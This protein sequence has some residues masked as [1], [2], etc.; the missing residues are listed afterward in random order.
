[1]FEL[2]AF[3]RVYLGKIDIELVVTDAKALITR[4]SRN[5]LNDVI[6]SVFLRTIR[7]HTE[8]AQSTRM[9]LN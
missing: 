7:V 6:S 4:Q 9:R 5:P 1:M 8:C 3:N 2:F